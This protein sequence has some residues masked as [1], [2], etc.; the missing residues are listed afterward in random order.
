MKQSRMFLVVLLSLLLLCSTAEATQKKMSL[1]NSKTTNTAAKEKPK[2]ADS[3][4]LIRLAPGISVADAKKLLHQRG[5][6]EK[7]IF[8]NIS[9]AQ[10]QAY[11]S[12]EPI[13]K[14]AALSAKNIRALTDTP[15]I[16]SASLNYEIYLVERNL[17]TSITD[18]A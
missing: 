17:Y 12:V 6:K 8:R 13:K 9:M 16:D 1:G 5:L 14:D 18:G 4:L 7:K 15:E 3:S 11:L 2:A 10:G